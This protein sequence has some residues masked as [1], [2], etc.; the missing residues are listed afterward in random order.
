MN[1]AEQIQKHLHSFGIKHIFGIVG[2]EAGTISFDEDNETEFILTRHEFSAGIAASS[3]SRFT[4][5]PQVCFATI[6]PGSTNLATALATAALDRYPLIAIAAQLETYEINY[7]NAHQCVDGVSMFKSLVKF[8]YEI[9][10]PEEIIPTINKALSVSTSQPLGPSFISIPIDIL[11]STAVTPKNTEKNIPYLFPEQ[12]QKKYLQKLEKVIAML[13]ASINPLIIVGDVALRTGCEAL[14]RKISEDLNIPVISSYSAKGALPPNHRLYYGAITPYMDSILEFPALQS[15]FSPPDLLLLFGYD[16]V[17]HLYPKLWDTGNH[18]KIIRISP[19]PN[20]T[21]HAL[22]TDIDVVCSLKEG[23]EYLINQTH[24]MPKKKE[25]KILNLKKRM[26]QMENDNKIHIEGVL[27]NQV[28]G[29]LNKHYDDY[30]LANDVGLHRHV[31]A[32]FYRANKPLDFVT[33]AGLSSFGTGLPLAIG[34]KIANPQRTV[35]VIAGDGGFHS[36]SGELETAVRLG[37]KIIILIFNNGQSG[38]IQRYQIMNNKRVNKNIT[39]FQP[40]NFA[41]LAKA[42]YCQGLKISTTKE[43]NSALKSADAYNGP[44]LIEIPIYYPGLYVN[45]YTKNYHI[46]KKDESS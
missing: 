43:L 44:T 19:F 8:A 18:K 20:N 5:K 17:E 7:N 28:L 45:K 31:S 1:V 2:R 11:M 9:K 40:V 15:I 38:L 29:I 10:T 14:I 23:L 32:L 37:L 26:K 13:K 3:Y 46:N 41:A 24:F 4:K 21:P 6:G 36:N 30:I 34:A 16:L 35:V 22:R 39:A 12:K 42:N 25:Y 27:P 33:S